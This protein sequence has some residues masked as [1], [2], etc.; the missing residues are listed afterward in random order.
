LDSLDKLLREEQVELA[1]TCAA[2]IVGIR[3]GLNPIQQSG[4][5]TPWVKAPESEEEQFHQDLVWVYKTL[6]P[7]DR[8][9]PKLAEKGVYKKLR[10][11]AL[12]DFWSSYDP[13]QPEQKP[14][15]RHIPN[16]KK[17][18]PVPIRTSLRAIRKNLAEGGHIV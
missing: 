5:N 2:S 15:I 9:N 14:Y 4:F 18:L 13:E 17:R 1:V 12:A 8:F 7:N 16:N 6:P 10:L 11:K 3:R